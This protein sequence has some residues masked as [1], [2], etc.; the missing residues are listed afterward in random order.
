MKVVPTS[1]FTQCAGSLVKHS[2]VILSSIEVRVR[3]ANKEENHIVK[4]NRFPAGQK[5]VVDMTQALLDSFVKKEKAASEYRHSKEDENVYKRYTA[6]VTELRSGFGNMD[7]N[8][9]QEMSWISP[10]LLSSCIR[11]KNEDIRL[12]VQK[13]VAKTSLCPLSIPSQNA[14]WR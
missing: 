4:S 12:M 14:C 5:L 13:L 10:V 11:S 9:L 2:L 1:E 3:F 6:L 8:H 7:S